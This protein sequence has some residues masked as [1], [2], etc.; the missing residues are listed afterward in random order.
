MTAQRQRIL[1]AVEDPL[2]FKAPF[3]ITGYTF[4]A[5]PVVVARLET[6][7]LAGEGEA[8][9]VYYRDENP[10]A[11]LA[12]IESVQEE[13][14]AGA[15][16][17]TLRNLLPAGGARNAL[18]CAL[19]DLES[20][21]AGRPVWA[22]AGLEAPRPLITTFTIGAADPGKMAD[23]ALGYVQARSLKLKLTGDPDL[24]AER[25]RAVRK[26]RPDVWIGVDANQGLTPDTLE[27]LLPALVDC[28]VKLLEQPFAIGR[29]ADL[30]GIKLPL[31]VAADESVQGLADIEALVGRFDIVNIKL[32]KCGGLTEGLMMVAEARRLGLGV[33]VGNMAGS[34]LALA[35]GF[36]LGQLCDIVD[37][38]GPVFI[39]RDRDPPVVYEDGHVSYPAN[40]WGG[41]A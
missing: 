33:M 35:P 4:T 5:W 27:A 40:G 28:D 9:G 18:D 37:L 38:D 3:T 41:G 26:A 19:W 29:E 31:P 6:G 7:G 17:Q 8:S 23:D 13:I 1:S 14:E 12:T 36:L 39:S 30:E 11:M 22:L 20:R 25:L 32:D 10:A 16:R 24:E 34:S 2:P 21:Q 15:D